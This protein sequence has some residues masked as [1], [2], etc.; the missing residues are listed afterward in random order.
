MKPAEKNVLNEQ[1]EHYV[2]RPTNSGAR[3]FLYPEWLGTY[4]YVP[5]YTLN[6]GP[7]DNFLLF[8]IRS[9]RF[10]IDLPDRER[11]IAH[12]GDFVLIDCYKPQSYQALDASEVLWIHFNGIS[13]RMYYDFI[14]ERKG[15]VFST[16]NSQFAVNRLQRICAGFRAGK[17]MSEPVMSRYLTDI[18]TECASAPDEIPTDESSH[19]YAMEDVQEFI[20]ANLAQE[21]TNEELADMAC[22]SPGYFIK[23]FRRAT[24][25]TPHAFI[26]NARMDAAKRM[27]ADSQASLK[28]ICAKCGFSSPS[29]FCLAFKRA[30]GMTPLEY[31]RSVR[32]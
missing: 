1:S 18:L 27:L 17:R 20:V 32:E 12:A 31:R 29:A 9:G 4:R 28:Q 10:A 21:L 24:G 7:L 15:N 3:V 25:V 19:R 14:S 6:R 26:V 13:A 11:I 8:F 23:E 5:G 30:Q 16:A 2:Y 22:M